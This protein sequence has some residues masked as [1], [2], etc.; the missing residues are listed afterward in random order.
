MPKFSS[1][2][3][4]STDVIINGSP[5]KVDFSVSLGSDY[6]SA[7]AVVQLLVLE[8]TWIAALALSEVYDLFPFLP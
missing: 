6:F 7:K 2:F 5:S 1:I 4:F 3:I 8:V